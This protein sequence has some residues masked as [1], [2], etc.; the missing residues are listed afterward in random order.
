[1]TGFNPLKIACKVAKTGTERYLKY[2]KGSYTYLLR[3]YTAC[4]R[5]PYLRNSLLCRQNILFRLFLGE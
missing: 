1:M 2:N 3:T 4:L 5:N